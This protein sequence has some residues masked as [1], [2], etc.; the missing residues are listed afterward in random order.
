[1]SQ[2]FTDRVALITGGAG[3]IGLGIGRRLAAEG[4]RVLLADTVPPPAE[5]ADF[6]AAYLATD[7]TSPGECAAATAEA[8]GRWGRLDVLVNAAGIGAG[9]RVA[10]LD[11]ATWDR[12]LAVNLKGAFVMSRAAWPALAARAGAIVNIASLAGLVVRP[13]MG[14]YAASK[15]GLIQLT[16][17]LAVEGAAVGLRA[18]AVCPVWTDTPMLHAFLEHTGHP[19]RTLKL[20]TAGIPAGR[21]ATV[22][23]VAAAVAFLASEE[24][25]FIT[26][27]ALP[28]DGGASCV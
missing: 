14:A 13:E 25:R 12:V 26:G 15:A 7:V 17:V 23:D 2:R 11:D 20:I 19:A 22:E 9:A 8:V 16:R 4:A 10:E 3:G 1:M 27:V 5:A 24:A 28:V 6:G 18:N 21:V